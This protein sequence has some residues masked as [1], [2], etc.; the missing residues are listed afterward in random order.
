MTAK[1]KQQRT[2]SQGRKI[3]TWSIEMPDKEKYQVAVNMIGDG[4]EIRFTASCKE[5]LLR[6]LSL[7][8]PDINALHTL[9]HEEA[10]RIADEYLGGDWKKAA[11]IKVGQSKGRPGEQARFSLTVTW[12]PLRVDRS[13]APGNT[14]EMHVIESGSPYVVRQRSHKDDFKSGEGDSIIQKARMRKDRGDSVSVVDLTEETSQRLVEM[15]ELLLLFNERLM[16]RMGPDHTG[17]DGIPTKE[18]IVQL[19]IDANKAH[20]SGERSDEPN[21]DDFLI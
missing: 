20:N 17:R 4:E 15:R 21:P 12:G 11:L 6:H 5:G 7:S 19:M 9:V 14:G 10:S 2:V 18:E 1:M 3:D 13:R 16:T 8:S